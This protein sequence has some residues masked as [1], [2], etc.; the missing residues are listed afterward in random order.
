M[1]SLRIL[2][3]IHHITHNDIVGT[4]SEMLPLKIQLNQCF[5]KFYNKCKSPESQ[6]VQMIKKGGIL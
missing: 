5:A 3:R 6:H 1:K 2:W 4:M